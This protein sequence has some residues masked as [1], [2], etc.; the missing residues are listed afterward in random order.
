ME[1]AVEVTLGGTR[2]PV[3]T[4]PL[5]LWRLAVSFAKAEKAHP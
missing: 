3:L 4:C 5:G 1:V 2:A